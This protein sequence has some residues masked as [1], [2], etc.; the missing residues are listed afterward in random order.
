[1]FEVA[2]MHSTVYGHIYGFVS[3]TYY[4]HKNVYLYFHSH[5]LEGKGYPFRPDVTTSPPYVTFSQVER[6][7][8]RPDVYT[9]SMLPMLLTPRKVFDLR[10]AWQEKIYTVQTHQVGIFVL[11]FLWVEV[12]VELETVEGLLLG[13]V[14]KTETFGSCCEQ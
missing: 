14:C 4:M 13:S 5:L 10:A 1:M 8:E 9:W 12:L 6:Y 7:S 2:Y 3:N 11:C